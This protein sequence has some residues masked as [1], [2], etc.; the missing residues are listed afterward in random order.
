[1]PKAK[2]LGKGVYSIPEASHL[3]NIPTSQI[4]RW[5]RGYRLYRDSSSTWRS[6]V[7]TPDYGAIGD[8]F[9]LS[10]LDLVEVQFIAW[11][12]QQGVSWRAIRVAAAN[13][14]KLLEFGHPFAKRDFF[15]DGSGILARIAKSSG[16][17]ELVNLVSSQYEIDQLVYPLL[18]QNLDFGEGEMDV[19]N[20][21][22]PQ[23]RRAGIVVDPARN[24]GRPIVAQWNIPTA[25]LANLFENVGSVDRVADWYEIDVVAVR[26]AVEFEQRTAA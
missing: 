13:A 6:P 21:W 18:Y 16:E 2:Y 5:V 9:A 12:R 25:V 11:F 22:W 8:K 24:M 4:R 10:F 23:G 3:T 7:F 19:A 20:R 26:Q 15:T 1:M 17:Q 14:A